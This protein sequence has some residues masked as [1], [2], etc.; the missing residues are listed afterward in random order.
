M[1]LRL[2]SC[3]YIN[4]NVFVL[5]IHICLNIVSNSSTFTGMRERSRFC[6][7]PPGIPCLG[8]DTEQIP[9]KDIPPCPPVSAWAE[10]S[11]WSKCDC[12]TGMQTRIR[13]CKGLSGCIGKPRMD[14]KCDPIDLM[15]NCPKQGLSFCLLTLIF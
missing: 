15:N 12:V 9:C 11:K 10:W 7:H 2:S 14:R 6:N 13:I 4:P 8:P 3:L 5:I 1:C